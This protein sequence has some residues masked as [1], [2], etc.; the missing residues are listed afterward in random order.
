MDLVLIDEEVQL[1]VEDLL[2]RSRL[3]AECKCNAG[4]ARRNQ[5]RPQQFSPSP[6]SAPPHSLFLFPSTVK[7]TEGE[8]VAEAERESWRLDRDA[9][10]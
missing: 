6:L 5:I 1:L 10:I 8:K 9:E 7:H 3:N 4:G 2:G